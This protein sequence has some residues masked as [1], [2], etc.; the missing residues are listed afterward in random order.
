MGVVPAPL[1]ADQMSDLSEELLAPEDGEEE[2]LVDLLENRVPP[3]VDDAA[4]VKAAFLTAIAKGDKTSPLVTP[5]RATELLGTML[6]GY[7]IAPLVDLLDD[8]ELGATAADQLKNILLM[9]DAFYDVE[10]KHKAGNANATAVIESW[11]AAEW[12]LARPPLPHA[13]RRSALSSTARAPRPRS[14]PGTRRR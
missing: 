1:D 4:Y 9:F 12:F 13:T 10:E 11:A 8:A 7:N 6:G 5:L 2:F 14:T 3:G